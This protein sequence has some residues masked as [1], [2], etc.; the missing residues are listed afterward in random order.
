MFKRKK[1]EPAEKADKFT[2][3]N[4]SGFA[5]LQ[6]TVVLFL[7]GLIGLSSAFYKIETTEQ[8]V[9]TRF[10]AFSHI[11]DSGA[12]FKLPFGIDRVYKVEVTSIHELQFGFRKDAQDFQ[13]VTAKRESLMLTGDLNVAVVQWV[14]QWRVLDPRKFLFQAKNV[15]KNIR[16]SSI[17]VMRRVVGD[18]LVSDVLT[19]DRITIAESAK[20]LTQEVI[21]TYD[22]GVLITTVNLQ[23]VMPPDPVKPAFNEINIAKQEQEQMINKAKEKFNEVIP[24]AKGLANQK[25]TESE[26]Y[27]INVVNK[28]EGDSAR[29]KEV[30]DAY[31]DSPEITRKRLYLE[32][33]E[34]I[35]SSGKNFM[36]VDPEIKGLLPIYG[37]SNTTPQI[38]LYGNSN[39]IP[40]IP[41]VD[42]QVGKG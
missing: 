10:G 29:F 39:T 37:N 6:V 9:V 7:V 32:A 28:A 5:K 16:D 36:I 12:H 30:L 26:A 19:T 11:V 31:K 15:E 34:E 35:F 18:K 38:P 2:F 1:K 17:S 21:D 27:A 13:E 33:M 42:T 24:K 20:K 25:I 22:M 8:G 4:S 41:Q 40:Q 14:L 23:N 3:S